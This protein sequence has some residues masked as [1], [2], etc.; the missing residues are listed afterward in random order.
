MFNA[1]NFLSIMIFGWS[2]LVGFNSAYATDSTQID[3][4]SVIVGQPILIGS[5]VGHVPSY[6]YDQSWHNIGSTPPGV[7]PCPP[8]LSP[9]IR[10]SI[11]GEDDPGG[12]CANKSVWFNVQ[13][14]P[15]N[16]TY[17]TVQGQGNVNTPGGC[18]DVGLTIS[19]VLYCGR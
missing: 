14:V 11:A 13:L 19:W 17:Y 1:R 7:G 18:S 4:P 3:T 6:T 8:P 15:W 10:A 5:G 16:G 12:G 2:G 9:Q